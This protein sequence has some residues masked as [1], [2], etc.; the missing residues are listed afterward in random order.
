MVSHE[1]YE[2][3]E[4]LYF[5]SNN[6]FCLSVHPSVDPSVDLSAWLF[7][8]SDFIF[9]CQSEI[10]FK[11][12]EAHDVVLMNL[13]YSNLRKIVIEKKNSPMSFCVR[14]HELKDLST[15]DLTK[16]GSMETV[17]LLVR[18]HGQCIPGKVW[19]FSRLVHRL[20]RSSCKFW[21]NYRHRLFASNHS[22]HH[23]KR[24][25][26]N[27]FMTTTPRALELIDDKMQKNKQT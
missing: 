21:S 6:E 24:S 1:I 9:S 20:R 19:P 10:L 12:F 13:F 5:H 22:H 3:N 23:L 7:E 8:L 26:Q 2:V 17:V 18:F 15:N 25:K 16:H 14:N 27:K 11:R 4:S